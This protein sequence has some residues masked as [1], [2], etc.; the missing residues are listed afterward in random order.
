MRLIAFLFF[1][2]M[3]VSDFAQTT[4]YFKS[5]NYTP[6]QARIVLSPE[7]SQE[8]IDGYL[9]RLIIFN[10]TPNSKER[11]DL[12]NKGIDLLSYIPT[13]SYLARVEPTVTISSSDGIYSI[14]PLKPEFKL[15]RLLKEK[16]YPHWTLFGS[17]EIELNG[18]VYEGIEKETIN[19][20]LKEIGAVL[21]KMNSA[22]I[23]HLRIPIDRLTLLYKLP[24]F[25][26]FETLPPPSEPENLPGRTDHRSNVLAS[27]YSGGLHYDG[28]GV[29]VMLQDDGVIGP[30]IDYQGRVNQSY[31]T[32]CSSLTGNNHGDHVAGTIMGAGNLN[33]DRKGMAFGANLFVF[34]STNSNYDTVPY[35]YANEGVTVT[36]KSYSSGCNSGYD[37]LA[38]QL[39][40]QTHDLTSLIHVF[41][42]GNNGTYDC[43]YG[44]GAG[45]GNITGGH[46]S[47][48]NVIAV[49]NLDS[50]DGINSSS[51]RGPATDG[52]LKPDVSA[53]GTSV[54]STIS[55]NTYEAKTGTSMSCPGVSGTITQLYHSYKA[56][57]GGVNPPS[58]LIKA[59][60]LNTAED[61]GNPGPD[62]IHGWGRINGVKAY[63]LLSQGNY[64]IDSVD[65]GGNNTHT[66]TIPA[67]LK[68]LKVMVY[69]TD[70]EGNPSASFALV[71][72]I[73]MSITDPGFNTFDPWVLDHSP[74]APTLNADA[75]RKKD[76]LNNMEQVTLDDPIPGT[77]TITVDGYQI[78]QGPQTYFMVYEYIFE[79]ITVTYPQGGEALTPGTTE[80]IRWDASRDSLNGFNIEFSADNGASWSLIATANPN[81]L[82]CFWGIP[83][84]LT[85]EA[86]IRV[87]RGAVVDAGDAVFSIMEEPQNLSFNW[88]CP[89][90]MN[91]AWDP[92]PGATSYTAY[93]LGS[94]YMDSIGTTI[95]TSITIPF[96][97][98]S[99]NWFSVRAHGPNGVYSERAVAVRKIPGQFGCTWSAPFADIEL[100]CD[101]VSST[102]CVEVF[103]ASVNVDASATYQWY[104][105]TGTPSTSTDENPIVCFSNSGYQDAALV[106]TNAAGS[107]SVY[108]Y[109]VV[110]VQTA[111]ELPYYE[112]FESLVTFNG[113]E[114][115]SVYNPDVN[116]SFVLTTSASYT[117][118][119]SAKLYNHG[120]AEGSID[121][122][123]SGPVNLST[124]DPANDSITMTFRYAH[125]NR[126]SQ[127]DDFLRVYV[128]ESCDTWWVLRKTMHGQSLS[129]INY[130]SPWTP[131]DSSEWTTVHITNISSNY[132][133]GDFR[134]KFNFENGNGNN[135]YLDDINI[136]Q[137]PP[138]NQII[139]GVS[140]LNNAFDFSVY[141][142][143]ADKDIS[144]RFNIEQ[145]TLVCINITDINGRKV[146][147]STV[148]ASS[149][150]NL[151][152]MDADR[153]DTG[154]YFVNVIVNGVS[155]IKQLVIR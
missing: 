137:G 59:A 1:L 122:L 38:M 48:K 9:Y 121:E 90:S 132:F 104:F 81:T 21:V 80:V 113:Q 19:R 42:A 20:A 57:H 134:F 26:Y 68:Q 127:S 45:W 88:S 153:L 53:V 43:G 97:S 7:T 98:T 51:S 85:G 69:W 96:L 63:E 5:G 129:T 100:L 139:V 2:G 150:N 72:N 149:G 128:K 60:V 73:N 23:I 6:T 18:V 95:D 35:L 148:K 99:D 46:K 101:S 146:G 107:D 94:K 84:T 14:E 30:H 123:I 34:S 144:V 79:K 75:I 136:Y 108:F 143:P 28:T 58:G 118:V 25:Y 33:P 70:V 52:R 67:G 119:K 17:D 71:N 10:Q 31:C 102:N 61:L 142:N 141:P 3:Y 41:S 76:S 116:A 145:G 114:T 32:S 24:H 36:S 22:G 111:V 109:N 74:Y 86:M 77:Y 78:P 112:D 11:A 40:Q 151:V 138:S 82:S 147:T 92:V 37:A 12:K 154:M 66:L 135:F 16:T 4:L 49:A 130:N 44:A 39:D 27:D 93:M 110:Y 62:F 54:V 15:T 140:E 152:M 87:S 65:Q 133:S 126:D 155:H 47:G 64:L 106:V 29:K 55:E 50:L 8:V 83:D 115:W 89:D 105:P 56:E 91:F 125:R 124:L 13:N 131:A 117:G 103:N 120:Q